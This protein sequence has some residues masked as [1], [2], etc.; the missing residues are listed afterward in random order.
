MDAPPHLLQLPLLAAAAVVVVGASIHPDDL[1]ML[2]DMRGTLTNPEVPARRKGAVPCS[3]GWAH[4]S[5][6]RGGRVNDLD[7]K[8]VGLADDLSTPHL[9][10]A[11]HKTYCS[12]RPSSPAWIMIFLVFQINSSSAGHRQ[13]L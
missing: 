5:C 7:L 13:A 6:D 4:V 11:M 12:K 2:K 8:N 3:G 10:P 9:R 1:A